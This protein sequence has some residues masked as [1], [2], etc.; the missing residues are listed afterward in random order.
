MNEP[1]QRKMEFSR[2]KAK[3]VLCW[4]LGGLGVAIILAPFL[5]MAAG[6][7]YSTVIM[8]RSS[9]DAGELLHRV[10]AV[11]PEA[12]EDFANR[13][14]KLMEQFQSTADTQG[15]GRADE[16]LQTLEL[17]GEYPI[18]AFIRPNYMLSLSYRRPSRQG[19]TV[20]YVR[21]NGRLLPEGPWEIR[22]WT[23]DGERSHRLWSQETVNANRD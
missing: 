9:M 15:I 16:R 14:S 7:L 10:R 13:C 6:T 22:A 5:W 11:P 21:K 4:G 1:E 12:M 23:G 2:R 8:V 20:Q 17:A 3:R 18:Y 19:L